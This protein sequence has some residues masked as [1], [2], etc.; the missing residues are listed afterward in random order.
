MTKV[1]QLQAEIA[2]LSPEDARR[3]AQWLEEFLSD[4][5]DKQ[6]EEDAKAGRLDALTEQALREID[7]GETQPLDDFLRNP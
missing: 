6:I 2:S 5:W 7:A 4:Q 1:E 3:V